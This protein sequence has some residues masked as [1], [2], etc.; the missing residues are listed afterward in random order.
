MDKFQIESEIKRPAPYKGDPGKQ[1]AC[2]AKMEEFLKLYPQTRWNATAT[3]KLVGISIYTFHRWKDNPW[4]Q[5]H[6]DL[7]Q[8]EYKDWL[9]HKLNEN[10]NNN[11]ESSVIFANKTVNRDRGYSERHSFMPIKLK[12]IETIEDVNSAITEIIELVGLG[13]LSIEEGEKY[14]A[15]I[16][17]KR[18][19]LELTDLTKRMDEI[20]LKV[21]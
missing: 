10:I 5:E 4:F 1:K 3:C 15:L 18:K 19:T 17:N 21:Q 12:R 16:E 7:A 2:D 11:M 8:F 6:L 14:G 9:V 13:K 20:E